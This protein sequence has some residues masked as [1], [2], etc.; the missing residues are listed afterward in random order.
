MSKTRN[1]IRW[2]PS[3]GILGK[4]ARTEEHDKGSGV[5]RGY[6]V[7]SKGILSE[8]SGDSRGWESDE[9]TIAQ[10]VEH[11][12]KSKHGVKVRFGHPNMSSTALG[13]FLGR[14]RNFRDTKGDAIADLYFNKTAFKTPNGDLAGYVLDLAESDPA[15]FGT[16]LV[17]DAD[18]VPRL[19]EDGTPQKDKDGR[20]KPKLIR[21]NRLYASDVVDDP[22]ANR[23]MFESFLTPGVQL[24]AKFSRAI[25]ELMENEETRAALMKFVEDENALE[26][27]NS[28][29]SRY[30][31][32]NRILVNPLS[33]GDKMS[34][35]VKEATMLEGQALGDYLENQPVKEPENKSSV[36]T[37][38]LELK[39]GK[40]NTEPFKEEGVKFERERVS[41]ILKLSNEIGG[42][43]KIDL[44][45]EANALIENGVSAAEAESTLYKSALDKLSAMTIET[46]GPNDEP[47][48]SG[49][50]KFHRDMDEHAFL[51]ACDKNW[52]KDAALRREFADDKNAYVAFQKAD[53]QGLVRIKN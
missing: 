3:T 10:V 35:E 40:I 39:T 36:E 33:K 8:I 18:F 49:P 47:K 44:S 25:D 21:I 13:T 48:S 52:D 27:I 6:K 26:N 4:V 23:E 2:S 28:F 31:N 43:R 9:V 46:P 15:A 53:V 29:L 1:L 20:E 34:D 24:S 5:I 19:N 22:A 30:M 14:A 12:N 17:F 16:S 7:M 32:N 51:A 41:A 45:A 11:G 42:A 37:K 50:L 38:A